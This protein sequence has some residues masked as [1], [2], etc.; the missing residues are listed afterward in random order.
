MGTG[1]HTEQ[2]PPPPN[3]EWGQTQC[4]PSKKQQ[5][6]KRKSHS[7][8]AQ[9]SAGATLL[10]PT[11]TSPSSPLFSLGLTAPD[12]RGRVWGCG[13]FFSPPPGSWLCYPY[14]CTNKSLF[15]AT[16]DAEGMGVGVPHSLGA[17][18]GLRA[19]GGRRF[20]GWM[21]TFVFFSPPFPLSEPFCYKSP[22]A[23][24]G[25]FWDFWSVAPPKPPRP[26]ALICP[27]AVAPLGGSLRPQTTHRPQI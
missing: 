27:A 8:G 11:P 15:I 1:R 7:V 17:A 4:A 24:A 23:S 6:K 13:V 5:Q 21:P 14:Q 12:W 20:W 2:C 16:A 26:Q 18:V 19:A 25:L 3:T 10:P 22:I 9:N